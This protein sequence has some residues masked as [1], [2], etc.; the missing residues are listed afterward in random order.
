[1]DQ[2]M[3]RPMQDDNKNKDQNRGD[4]NRDGQKKQGDS[5]MNS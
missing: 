1:M 3:N 2:N 4:Q 5:G